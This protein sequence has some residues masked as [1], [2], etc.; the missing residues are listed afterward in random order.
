MLHLAFRLPLFLSLVAILA[1]A[2]AKITRGPY[3]QLAHEQG[4]TVV[5]R[6]GAALKN[7]RVGYWLGGTKTVSFCDREAILTRTMR[8]DQ[9]LAKSPK[10][11]FQYEATIAGLTPS[12]LYRYAIYEGATPLTEA[13]PEYRF[14]THP[15]I[16][17]STPTRVWVVG[18]SGTGAK[19]QALVHEAM[20]QYVATTKRFLDLY[21]HVGDMAYGQGTDPQFAQNFFAP[22]R[23]I[24]RNTVCWAAMGNHEGGSSNGETGVGPFYDAYVCPTKGEAGGVPSGMESF[25]SFDYGEIHFICLNSY[26]ISRKPDGEMAQWVRRDLAATKAKWIIG[27]WHHPPYTKG[28]H[29]SDTE[30]ELMEMREMIMPI[31][32]EGGIDLVLTGHSHI[33]ERSMLIDGAY[34]TPTTAKGVVLDDGDGRPGSDGPYLKSETRTPHNGTV[35][36]TT[37]HGGKLGANSLGILPLMRSIVLDHGST[38]LDIEGDTLT[39]IMVDLRGVERDRFA[40]RKEG[41]IKHTVLA[42]P[43]TPKPANEERTGF[44]VKGALNTHEAS[45]AARKAGERALAK[46][47]PKKFSYLIAPNAEWDYLAGGMEP[48]TEMW[49]MVGFDA[50]AE[51]AWKLGKVGIGYGDGDDKTELK[52]MRNKY[53]AVFLRK[54]FEIPKG[55]DLSRLGLVLNYDDG[56]VLYANGRMLLSKHITK[57]KDGRVTVTSHE[58]DGVEYFSLAEFAAAFVEGR[59]TLAFEAHNDKKSSTD[60]S[61]DPYLVVEQG[62]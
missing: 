3:L 1:P 49:T 48:E 35:A 31:L 30:E 55:T 7:P 50:P 20:R 29:D 26:D 10:G 4:I 21:V 40:I 16:G 46:K 28:T 5:W 45:E 36:V 52:G 34:Q 15:P 57:H 33:Y 58:A 44:G 17:E 6:T 60:F 61:L 47:L 37:G 23:D 59:N 62:E 51:E 43:W 24:L 12:T 56:F 13:G 27:F 8:S 53:T 39:G 32:E 25:Y 14:K 11:T 41:T 2:Q 38:I 19:H 54:D 18:D 22:Y 9:P 42:N